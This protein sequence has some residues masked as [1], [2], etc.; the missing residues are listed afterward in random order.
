MCDACLCVCAVLCMLWYSLLSFALS[1][2]SLLL[3]SFLCRLFSSPV[4]FTVVNSVRR[5]I[6]TKFIQSMRYS[7]AALSFRTAAV[8]RSNSTKKKSY[9][10]RFAVYIFYSLRPIWC[11]R[12]VKCIANAVNGTK[13]CR[14]LQSVK[15]AKTKVGV[16]CWALASVAGGWYPL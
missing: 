5:I 14:L 6:A 9:Q 10:R 16:Q 7:K 1:S 15:S 3:L 8:P 11:N 12:L 4:S 13:H 2:P